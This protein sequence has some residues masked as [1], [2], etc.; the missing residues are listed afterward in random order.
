MGCDAYASD[1]G[2]LEII[3][4]RYEDPNHKVIAHILIKDLKPKEKMA[5][6]YLEG[7]ER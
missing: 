7:E 1:D 3:I 6:E 5:V 2:I 4:E